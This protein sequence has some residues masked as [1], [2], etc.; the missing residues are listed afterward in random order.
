MG[1]S[2]CNES[3]FSLP[4]EGVEFHYHTFVTLRLSVS[5]SLFLCSTNPSNSPAAE[6][7][8][9]FTPT[10]HLSAKIAVTDG[11]RNGEEPFYHGNAINVGIE[12][13]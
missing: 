8:G 13:K 3:T 7:V 2:I 11:G 4:H 6:Q 5:L 9:N 12:L 1:E 10:K